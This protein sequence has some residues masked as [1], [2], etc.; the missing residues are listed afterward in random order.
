MNKILFLGGIMRFKMSNFEFLRKHK[1]SVL[2]SGKLAIFPLLFAYFHLNTE[3]FKYF[4]TN[5]HNK[6]LLWKL[7]R[8]LKYNPLVHKSIHI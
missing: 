4:N 1:T 8:W 3:T 5:L 2:Y 6:I 7:L